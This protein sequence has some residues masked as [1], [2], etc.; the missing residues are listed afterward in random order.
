MKLFVNKSIPEL[1][2]ASQDGHYIVE[3]CS[4]VDLENIVENNIEELGILFRD[5]WLIPFKHG[6][7][8]VGIDHYGN[9]TK[10]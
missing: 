9:V 3:N 10:G 2:I 8:L 5:L 4:S 7:E 6:E 1:L